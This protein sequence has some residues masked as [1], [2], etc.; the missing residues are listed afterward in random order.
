MRAGGMTLQAIADRLN[1]ERIPTV[2]DGAEWRPSSV[3][4]A[5]C[6]QRPGSLVTKVTPSLSNG[7][8]LAQRGALFLDSSCGD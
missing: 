8:N 2:R 4:S 1:A 3:Q 7:K 6:Y 5:A